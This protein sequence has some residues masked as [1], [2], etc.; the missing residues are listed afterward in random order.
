MII[1]KYSIKRIKNLL[2]KLLHNHV[3]WQLY[4]VSENKHKQW[5]RFIFKMFTFAS[6]PGQL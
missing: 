4:S 3:L 6:Y 1:F 5:Y 2:N